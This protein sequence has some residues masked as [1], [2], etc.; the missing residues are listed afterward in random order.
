MIAVLVLSLAVI[1]AIVYRHDVPRPAVDLARPRSLWRIILCFVL[2]SVL[3][4][5]VERP[6]EELMRTIDACPTR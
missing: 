4:V 6:L 1:S 2:L 5:L 3:L